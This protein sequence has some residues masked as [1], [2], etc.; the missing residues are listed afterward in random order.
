MSDEMLDLTIDLTNCDREPIHI[1]GLV[2][3]HGVLLVL[4]G[5]TLEILQVSR[6]TFELLGCSVEE[7]L[8]RPLTDLLGDEQVKL[9]QHCLTEDF[10]SINPL[11]LLIERQ[12]QSIAFD[13]IV[14][15]LDSFIVLELEPNIIESH[16]N[17][18]DFYH[19][20]KGPITRIQKAPTL[21]KMCQE[22]QYRT[23]LAKE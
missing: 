20:V 22:A 16:A 6:N 9:I 10:E 12:Q 18:S 5:S 11:N 7:L 14:H 2:Q 1:P 17:F 3:P 8:G 4:H 19:Q 15:R 13:G 21:L 23:K